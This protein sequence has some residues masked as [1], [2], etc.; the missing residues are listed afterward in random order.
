MDME[1][2][3][4]IALRRHSR[5]E[6]FGTANLS[7]LHVRFSLPVHCRRRIVSV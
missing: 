3:A 5:N 2:L 1:I 7:Q 4:G 6:N